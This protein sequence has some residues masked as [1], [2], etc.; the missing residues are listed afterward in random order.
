MKNFVVWL[1]L[2][3]KQRTK[4]QFPFQIE[5]EM[6]RFINEKELGDLIQLMELLFAF[7]TMMG[8]MFKREIFD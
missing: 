3:C 6:F 1:K 8:L 7:Q 4:V 5:L 2:L